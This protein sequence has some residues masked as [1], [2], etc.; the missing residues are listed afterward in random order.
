MFDIRFK[1]RLPNSYMG[2]YI[3]MDGSGSSR[4]LFSIKYFAE[5]MFL[6]KAVKRMGLR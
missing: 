5:D 2:I 4:N 6:L 3:H 1:T